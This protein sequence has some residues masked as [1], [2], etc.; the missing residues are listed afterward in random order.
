[1]SALLR[2]MP[3]AA[4]PFVAAVN[5]SMSSAEQELVYG[6]AIEGL[7]RKLDPY[8]GGAVLPVG[9][10]V[11]GLGGGGPAGWRLLL[12]EAEALLGLV[13]GSNAGAPLKPAPHGA[14][15]RAV[16][17]RRMAEEAAKLRCA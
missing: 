14:A 6:P 2:L 10:P 4:A 12:D 13:G 8:S 5:V 1:M 11:G 16:L 9:N 3:A 15:A 17:A 7:L